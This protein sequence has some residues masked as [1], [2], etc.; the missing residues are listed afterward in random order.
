MLVLRPFEMTT[1]EPKPAPLI[2]KSCVGTLHR[3]AHSPFWCLDPF[4]LKNH[5]RIL[6]T[7]IERSCATGGVANDFTTL[8]PLRL[9]NNTYTPNSISP[10]ITDLSK[11]QLNY[12]SI[13]S[14]SNIPLHAAEYSSDDAHASDHDDLRIPNEFPTD[15]PA[16]VDEYVQDVYTQLNRRKDFPARLAAIESALAMAVRSESPFT[17]SQSTDF[18]YNLMELLVDI[19]SVDVRMKF[20]L[21]KLE[22]IKQI[23]LRINADVC[24]LLDDAV[25]E[26][27]ENVILDGDKW[28]DLWQKFS[29]KEHQVGTETWE[30]FQRWHADRVRDGIRARDDYLRN[31]Q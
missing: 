16:N 15:L 12:Q 1:S 31:R 30:N 20:L 17:E 26:G 2:E 13:P 9:A 14:M 25:F 6:R 5:N 28:Q 8:T 11:E 19:N 23:L 27:W 29:T 18:R 24:H 4:K 10:S 7:F 21:E 3:Q 22:S